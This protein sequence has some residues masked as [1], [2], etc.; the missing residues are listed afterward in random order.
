M[1]YNIVLN[2]INRCNTN[3]Q[4]KI[5]QSQ[6]FFDWSV[7][8]EGKYNLTFT[9]MSG[10]VN[11]SSVPFIP[12]LNIALG[13]ST[14]YTADPLRISSLITNTI[15]ILIP[16][17]SD[18]SYLYADKNVNHPITLNR[19]SQNNFTVN[20]LNNITNGLWIDTAFADLTTYVLTL[21]LEQI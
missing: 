13:Q 8:P 7:L 5:T 4:D 10:Q 14:N 3:F 12:I 11:E 17:I 20:I 16:L 18:K 1:I 2:P 9:F 19:P 21:S 6:Y 15:G